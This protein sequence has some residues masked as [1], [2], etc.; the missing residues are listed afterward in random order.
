MKCKSVTTRN[1]LGMQ[2]SLTPAISLRE[3]PRAET[4]DTA[5]SAAAIIAHKSGNVWNRDLVHSALLVS[6]HGNNF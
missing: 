2:H 3:F 6:S 5:L 4:P 1:R